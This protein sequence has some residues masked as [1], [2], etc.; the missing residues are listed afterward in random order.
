[1]ARLHNGTLHFDEASS[2]A[3]GPPVIFEEA[4]GTC[5]L[6]SQ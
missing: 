2:P 3:C 5:G 6:G 1:M 4:G